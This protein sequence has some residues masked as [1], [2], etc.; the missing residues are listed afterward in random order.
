MLNCHENPIMPPPRG[1]VAVSFINELTICEKSAVFFLRY[2]GSTKTQPAAIGELIWQLGKEE[3]QS[4][5]QCLDQ[6][7]I[8][9][10]EKSRRPFLY[11]DVICDCVGAHEMCFAKLISLSAKNQKT[12]AMIF[13]NHLVKPQALEGIYNLAQKFSHI[14]NLMIRPD[15]LIE[16]NS[17]TAN[18]ENLD[19]QI[20]DF[21][22]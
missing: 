19:R 9:L 6:I 17:N 8:I 1:A 12:D 4:G 2:W 18:K 21:V 10:T 3:G 14:L 15:N 13:A 11:H 5:I 22:E 7:S 16:R 20:I